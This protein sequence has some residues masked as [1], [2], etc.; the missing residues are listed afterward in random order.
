MIVKKSHLKQF[1]NKMI[2]KTYE[3]S[4]QGKSYSEIVGILLGAPKKKGTI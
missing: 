3:L 1:I 2:E 4:K